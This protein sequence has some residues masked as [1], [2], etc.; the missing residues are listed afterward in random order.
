MGILKGG[1]RV[2]GG[3]GFISWDGLGLGSLDAQVKASSRGMVGILIVSVGIACSPDEIQG[4]A[5]GLP[6]FYLAK[7]MQNFLR[8]RILLSTLRFLVLCRLHC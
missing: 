2:H 5:G 8:A 4:D 3:D 6:K 7:I 1:L